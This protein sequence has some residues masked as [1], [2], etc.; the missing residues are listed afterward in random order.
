MSRRISVLYLPA[1]QKNLVNPWKNDIITAIGDKHDL[2]IFDFEKPLA[3]QFKNIDLVIDHGGSIGTRE[4]A[5]LV[6]GKIL[7]WQI[8]GTGFDHFDLNYWKSKKIPVSNC[9]GTFSAVALAE[10]AM[11]LTLMLARKYSTAREILEKG[12]MSEP[13]GREMIGLKLG[14]IGLGASGKELAR[15]ALSFG[16]KILAIDIREIGLDEINEFQ[17]EF[18]GNPTDLDKVLASSDVVSLHLHLNKETQ[19]TIN[20]RRLK[21]MK[22]TSFLI[23]VA[24]GKLINEEALL[25]ALL[26]N[27]I[28]GAGLDVYGQEPP[29]LSSPIFNLPNVVATPHISG[30]TDGTSRN[31]AAATAENVNR[32]AN[33]LKPLYRID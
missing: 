23:N 6:A 10:C 4:M 11:M 31:R 29:D 33:G 12:K 15:R 30:A 5:D 18:V 8:V 13:V 21:L 16:M 2:K 3:P 25:Q 7:L 17:L 32:I 14:I 19:H 28:A 26:E 27:E 20:A 9:P 1:P 24:R 22:K